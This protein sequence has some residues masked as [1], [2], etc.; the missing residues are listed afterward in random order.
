MSSKWFILGTLG[1]AALLPATASVGA[2]A[3]PAP[4]AFDD[5]SVWVRGH[6][7]TRERRTLIPAETRQERVPARYEEV[8]IPAVTEKV[9]MP[10]VTE[11]VWVHKYFDLGGWHRAHY[12][13]K[14]VSPGHFEARIVTPERRE[15]RLIEEAHW[16][17]VVVRPAHYEV[18]SERIWVPGHWE[19]R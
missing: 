7:E 8:F 4:N 2:A 13:D 1:L 11:R 3:E 12:E 17:T 10:A 19:S 9:W 5:S 14:I 6:F 18:S 16:Q 15:S